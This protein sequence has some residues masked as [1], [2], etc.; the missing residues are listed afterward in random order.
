MASCNK[1]IA[2]CATCEYWSGHREPDSWFDNVEYM[3]NHKGKCYNKRSWNG[4]EKYPTD[5][6]N[7]WQRW[8]VLGQ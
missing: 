2:Q 3:D 6:C 5:N 8:M 4:N 7:N 1:Q